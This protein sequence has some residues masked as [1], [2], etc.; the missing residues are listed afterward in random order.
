[1]ICYSS[2]T[3]EITLDGPL[4]SFI[5]DDEEESFKCKPTVVR[6]LADRDQAG[7][8]PTAALHQNNG[9]VWRWLSLSI[10]DVCSTVARTTFKIGENQTRL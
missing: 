4:K 8:S 3:D 9:R 5:R 6:G 7:S 2:R 1:M 10:R